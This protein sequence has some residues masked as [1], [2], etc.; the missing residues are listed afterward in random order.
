[1]LTYLRLAYPG[2]RA[3]TNLAKYLGMMEG[4]PEFPEGPIVK[5]TYADREARTHTL[6]AP[7]SGL[8]VETGL[9]TSDYVEEGQKL[10]HIIRDDALET[11][12]LV[13][14]VSGYL[15]EYG[16]HREHCDVALPPMHPYASEGDVVA[17]VMTVT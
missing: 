5:F 10:G 1:M 8:F 9:E 2:L 17:A 6:K 11:V 14:P 12:E 3:A 16:C 13:A 4:E 7:C 15:Y